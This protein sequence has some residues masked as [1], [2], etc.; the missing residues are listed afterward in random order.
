MVATMAV[1]LDANLAVLMAG[2]TGDHSAVL[3]VAD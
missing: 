3:M 1:S 2:L